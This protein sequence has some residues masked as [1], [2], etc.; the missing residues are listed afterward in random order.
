[1]ITLA[2]IVTTWSIMSCTPEKCIIIEGTVPSQVLCEAIL[3]TVYDDMAKKF[4][5]DSTLFRLQM[6]SRGFTFDCIPTK[7]LS[8]RGTE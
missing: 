4:N 8:A 1:M 5:Q 7:V 3:E 6:K 2:A